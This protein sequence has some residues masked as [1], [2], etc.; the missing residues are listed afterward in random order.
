MTKEEFKDLQAQMGLTN[1]AMAKKI[2]MSTRN[3]EDM[4]AG[5]RPVQPWTAKL[6]EYIIKDCKDLRVF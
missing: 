4:R 5:R 2:G 1:A 3:V 6:I